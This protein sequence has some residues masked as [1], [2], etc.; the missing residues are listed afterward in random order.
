MLEFF[1][2]SCR[3]EGDLVGTAVY[4]QAK[5]KDQAWRI[6]VEKGVL[7][8]K[9]V[10]PV[11]ARSW[12]RSRGVDP[13]APKKECL[14]DSVLQLKRSQ[15]ASLISL[16]KP[17]MD[18]L[19][20]MAGPDHL[21]LLCDAEGYVLEAVSCQDIN[22]PTGF[23]CTEEQ[24]GT[25]AIG[26]ALV[27]GKSVEVTGYEH[28]SSSY[29]TYSCA[30]VP[31][32]DCNGQIAAVI[33]ITNPRGDLPANIIKML[34]MGVKVIENQLQF[35]YEQLRLNEINKSFSFLMDFLQD[36]VLVVDTGGIIVSANKAALDILGLKE[37]ETVNGQSL[38]DLIPQN[39]ELV[40]QLLSDQKGNFSEHVLF[41]SPRGSINCSL[42]SRQIIQAADGTRQVIILFGLAKKQSH[43]TVSSREEFSPVFNSLIGETREWKNIKRLAMKAARVLSNVLIEGESGTGK[44]IV[45][46]AIHKESGRGGPFI[47][48]NCGAIP[49]ELLQSELFGYEDGSFTG[50]RKGGCTGKFEMADG[51]TVFLDEIG[52]MPVDMQ[53]SLLRFLQDKVITRVG[54]S[55]SKKVDV[56]IIAATN[57]NLREEVISGRFRED[58]FYRLNVINIDLPPLRE[59]KNDIPLI[60]Q[61]LVESL[62]NQFN[63]PVLDVSPETIEILC[64]YSWPGNVRELS[65]IIEHSVVFCEDDTI[66]PEILPPYLSEYRPLNL[67][68]GGDLKNYEKALIIKTLEQYNGNISKTASALGVA[69]NTLYRKIDKLGIR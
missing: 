17:I 40:D 68:T 25:N 23:H 44:E 27:E 10:R 11:V 41:K 13:A 3:M 47:A 39:P 7:P 54:S 1:A 38:T 19:S 18:D 61:Y 46:R 6:F 65:N 50:A 30:A 26:I 15:N 53:V 21:V 20:Y 55:K 31:I 22:P 34:E 62:C 66:T 64:R 49:K 69:R 35:K 67:H 58:L 33:D 59:R 60:T 63:R 56:R 52:E 12:Q 5:R 2:V 14:P 42:V 51:G 4:S 16:A 48:I 37:G 9:E 43:S 24:I 32:R 29:H 57:R 36:G 28:Y 8:E 45:A